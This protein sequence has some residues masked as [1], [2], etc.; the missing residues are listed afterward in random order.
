MRAGRVANA[1][2]H[3]E[4]EGRVVAH[5]RNVAAARLLAHHVEDLHL[6]A[7]SRPHAVVCPRVAAS[8]RVSTHGATADQPRGRG[9]AGSQGGDEVALL[10]GGHDGSAALFAAEAVHEANLAVATVAHAATRVEFG[11]AR[12]APDVRRR[13]GQAAQVAWARVI[14][15]RARRCARRGPHGDVG[16]VAQPR[17]VRDVELHRDLARHKAVRL[18]GHENVGDAS[19]G[20]ACGLQGQRAPAA[21]P[22]ATCS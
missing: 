9:A 16:N 3:G 10:G 6:A 18:R 12:V 8:A 15:S 20:V 2:H 1:E 7:R 11:R 13:A 5:G 19:H 17:W 22:R 4:V 21:P 14:S